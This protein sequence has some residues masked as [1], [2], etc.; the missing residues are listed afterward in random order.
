VPL[1][2]FSLADNVADNVVANLDDDRIQREMVL[3]AFGS[4]R[5]CF[6]RVLIEE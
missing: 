6:C 4:M 2:C 5:D 1:L 3:C